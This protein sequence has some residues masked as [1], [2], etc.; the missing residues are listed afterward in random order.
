MGHQNTL[1]TAEVGWGP[2][3]TSVSH[4]FNNLKIMFFKISFSSRG[5]NFCR[6]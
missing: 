6:H 3:D 5:I 2:S 1:Y 4:M